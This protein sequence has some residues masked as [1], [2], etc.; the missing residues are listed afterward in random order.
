MRGLQAS[1]RAARVRG[2]RVVRA[3]RAPLA[4]AW[5]IRESHLRGGARR[6]RGE[7]W[8]AAASF[9]TC[10]VTSDITHFEVYSRKKRIP[11]DL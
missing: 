5:S 4:S 6:I 11:I 8:R 1:L 9:L 7:R 3:S 10:A 2:A